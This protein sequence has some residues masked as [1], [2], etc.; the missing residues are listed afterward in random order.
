MAASSK[1]RETAGP[2]EVGV[3]PCCKT[4]TSSPGQG[5]IGR[6]YTAQLRSGWIELPFSRTAL[7]CFHSNSF[8]QMHCQ[9][10]HVNAFARGAASP[11]KALHPCEGTHERDLVCVLVCLA[12]VRVRDTGV[13]QI[14]TRT[15]T[16]QIICSAARR[17]SLLGDGMPHVQQVASS[18]CRPAASLDRR[19]FSSCICS[20]T[21]EL[22]LSM[23]CAPEMQD[24]SERAPAR[25]VFEM[26]TS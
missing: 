4:A 10:P 5:T 23:N 17:W 15:S 22:P 9:P 1:S 16:G 25:L 20:L 24:M 26:D 7:E 8:L 18:S 6:I 19:R 11:G 13:S 3:R 12:L 2:G 14:R 21:S